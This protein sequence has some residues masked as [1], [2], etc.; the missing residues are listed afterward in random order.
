[1]AQQRLARDFL[2]PLFPLFSAVCAKFL[3]LI[4]PLVPN[5]D[6]SVNQTI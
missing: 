3:A 2:H 4:I 5:N 1:M 6:F